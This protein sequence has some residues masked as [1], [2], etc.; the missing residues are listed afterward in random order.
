MEIEVSVISNSIILFILE[1]HASW[2][3][4]IS[5]FIAQARGLSSFIAQARGTS[6][7]IAQARGISSFTA[8]GSVLNG[9]CFS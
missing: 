9:V 1:V 4:G 6:S 8:S 5:S 2:K 3:V 7:F